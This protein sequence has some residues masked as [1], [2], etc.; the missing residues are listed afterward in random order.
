MAAVICEPITAG[1][2]EG[3]RSVVRRGPAV[4]VAVVEGVR[5]GVEQPEADA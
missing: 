2:V 5:R 1:D 4:A 3:M